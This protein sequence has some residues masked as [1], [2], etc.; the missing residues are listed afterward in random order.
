M[1]WSDDE[2]YLR[3]NC[4]GYE[5]LFFNIDSKRHDPSGASNTCNTSWKTQNC[6]LAW[7][8]QGIYPHGTDGS[9]INGVC[10]DKSSKLIA[11]GDDYTNKLKLNFKSY[12]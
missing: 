8:V 11:T 1:D 6:K 10:V 4:G 12:S 5:L 3:S 9:H 2:S 7:N